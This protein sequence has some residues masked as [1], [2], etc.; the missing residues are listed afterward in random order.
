MLSVAVDETIGA[1]V[2]VGEGA[3]VGFTI[4]VV[5]ITGTTGVGVGMIAGRVGV[6]MITGG[7][8]DGVGVG[9]DGT[10]LAFISPTFVQNP[11]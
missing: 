3:G 9:V 5:E 4:E 2:V 1:G 11:S 6:G 8:G 10:S 7:V